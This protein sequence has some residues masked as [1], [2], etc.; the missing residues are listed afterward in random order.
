MF[1]PFFFRLSVCDPFARFILNEEQGTAASG[2]LQRIV[3][4]D[5]NYVHSKLRIK[6]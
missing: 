6:E 1:A 2:S 3:S 5:T 4:F